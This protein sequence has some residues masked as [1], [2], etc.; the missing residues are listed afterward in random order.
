MRRLTGL[1]LIV[2]VLATR[3]PFISKMLYE[4]DSIDFAVAT[5]RFSL[6]QVTPHFPGYI[7]HVLFAKFLLFFVSDMNLAFVWISILLSIGSVLFLWRAGA[8]LRGERVGVITAVLWLFTPVFWFYGEVATAYLYEAFFA[9]A[10]LYFGISLLRNPNKSFLVYSL[11][12]I[13]SLAT[14]SRQSSIIFFTPCIVYCIWKTHQPFRLW[15]SG[16]I[17]F[18]VVTAIWSAILFSFAGGVGA[19]FAQA[20]SQTVYRSQSVFF[21]NSLQSHGAVIAKVLLYLVV[22]ALPFIIIVKV[23]LLCYWKRGIAFIKEQISK[24]T[25]RFTTLVALPAFLFYIGIYF[26]KAGYLLNILPSMVLIAAVLL[27]QAAIWHAERMKGRSENKLLLTRPIITKAVML[28]CSLIIAFDIGIYCI[29]FPWLCE[30]YSDNAFTF[31]SFNTQ[32]SMLDPKLGGGSGLFLNRLSSFN[33][34]HGVIVTDNIHSEVLKSLKSESSDPAGLVILDTWWHRWGYYY[35]PQSEI[36]DIRDFPLS[37]SLWIGESQNYIRKG[38]ADPVIHL[39]QQKKVL[40]LLRKDNPSFTS[41]S[42]Q[43][44]LERIP[45]PEYLDMFRIIDEHFSFKWKN[46][47]FIRD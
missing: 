32:A 19:Y 35:M 25:F 3:L 7:L 47:T 43:V 9:S 31:D 33:N 37:D 8:A 40:L 11:F 23:W 38:I 39:P 21:G 1:L 5:F 36:Y 27:D 22:S 16:L 20:D 17:V 29:P 41:I 14:G 2:T 4:F 34:V 46:V 6:E 18:L 28:Y 30:K 26:I 15:I 45:L 44:H 13:L 12:I 42:R 24:S 10:F